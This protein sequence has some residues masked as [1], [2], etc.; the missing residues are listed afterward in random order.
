MSR[1]YGE[2][3]GGDKIKHVGSG[4]FLLV[5]AKDPRPIWRFDQTLSGTVTW[6]N[7]NV[8]AMKRRLRQSI[9]GPDGEILVHSSV[10]PVEA[11]SQLALLLGID[12]AKSLCQGFLPEDQEKGARLVERHM[13]GTGHWNSLS[14]FVEFLNFAAGGCHF[15][16]PLDI[17][18]S[19]V[20]NQEIV[21]DL[22]ILLPAGVDP[23]LLANCQ[24]ENGNSTKINYVQI[25]TRRIKFDFRQVGDGDMDPRWQQDLLWN[26][27]DEAETGGGHLLYMAYHLVVQNRNLKNQHVT[28][29]WQG[30]GHMLPSNFLDLRTPRKLRSLA[31]LV[32]GYLDFHRYCVTP[33]NKNIPGGTTH[34]GLARLSPKFW[35]TPFPIKVA[36]WYLLQIPFDGRLGH[37]LGKLGAKILIRTPKKFQKIIRSRV[38]ATQ[39]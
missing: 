3:N 20:Q 8:V 32:E 14:E 23:I 31:E 39:Y 21:D 13:T 15:L 30:L 10:T 34:Y 12:L 9:S 22:D 5:V 19:Q 11:R 37:E 16:R 7:A 4:P 27:H 38:R 35:P 36:C 2:I 28:Y 25:G 18:E 1:L 24:T 29:I 33:I 17:G 6:S 26:F